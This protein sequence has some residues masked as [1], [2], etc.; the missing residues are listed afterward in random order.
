MR[1]PPPRRAGAALERRP[2]AGGIGHL[3]RS[4]VRVNDLSADGQAEAGPPPASLVVKNGSK[5]RSRDPV[6]SPVRS[7][8]PAGPP[9]RLPDWWRSGGIRRTA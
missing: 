8:R 3:D 5:I 2:A 6:R 7:R 1:R 9:L 4:T